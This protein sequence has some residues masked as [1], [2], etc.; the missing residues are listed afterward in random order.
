MWGADANA[1]FAKL[2]EAR[3]PVYFLNM[4]C[5]SPDCHVIPTLAASFLESFEA[6]GELE[7][8]SNA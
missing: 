8:A 6:L 2:G 5:R 4:T 1:L 7:G 3:A